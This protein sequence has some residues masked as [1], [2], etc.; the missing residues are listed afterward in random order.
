MHCY[1]TQLVHNFRAIRTKI[2]DGG[3]GGGGGEYRHPD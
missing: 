3:G 1:V 2:R